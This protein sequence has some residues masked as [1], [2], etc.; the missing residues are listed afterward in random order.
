MRPN[1]QRN[2]VPFRLPT[3]RSAVEFRRE[4]MCWTKMEMA[5]RLG[6]QRGH[7]TEFTKGQR[8]LPYGAMCLAHDLGVPASVLLQTRASKRAY[9]DRQARLLEAERKMKRRSK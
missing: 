8:R 4:A 3:I 9:E 7:Y 1:S 5:R 2:A 6:M